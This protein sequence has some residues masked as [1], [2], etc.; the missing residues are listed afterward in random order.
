MNE[1]GGA[2]ANKPGGGER[3][4]LGLLPLVW[5]RLTGGE[6]DA[7]A[8]GPPDVLVPPQNA[9]GIPSSAAGIEH[10]DVIG[11]PLGEVAVSG[12]SR[13]RAVEVDALAKRH[14]AAVF[15]RQRRADAGTLGQ[16]RRDPAAELPVMHERDELGLGEQVPKLVL[17]S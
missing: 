4:P 14:P 7:A 12:Q 1:R 17:A 11:A 8:Q 10:V 16:Q 3:S 13:D 5:R 6:V 9:L 2:Q 15:D